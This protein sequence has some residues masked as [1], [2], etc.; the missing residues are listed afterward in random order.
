L[1]SK[2]AEVKDKINRGEDVDI[3]NII[4]NID[5]SA[6]LNLSNI[7][8]TFNQ[9]STIAHAIFDIIYDNPI[10]N[11]PKLLEAIFAKFGSDVTNKFIDLCGE[12]SNTRE[13]KDI[14]EEISRSPNNIKMVASLIGLGHSDHTVPDMECS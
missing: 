8:H 4:N 2:L 10:L 11:H 7:Q 12:L 1:I 6:S 9:T 5:A 3:D 13:T 14:I